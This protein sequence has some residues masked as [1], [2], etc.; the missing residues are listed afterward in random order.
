VS[1]QVSGDQDLPFGQQWASRTPYLFPLTNMIIWGMGLPLGAAAWAGWAIAGW[2][3]FRRRALVHLIPWL[4][5]ALYFLWQGG[6][7]NPTM[8]YFA[9]LY[10]VLVIFAAWALVAL[11]NRRTMLRHAQEP[12]QGRLNDPSPPR[13]LS[14]TKGRA[15]ERQTIVGIIRRWSVVGGRWS[16]VFVVISTLCW[17]YAFTRIYTRPHSRIAAS[18]WIYDHIPPGSTISSEYWDDGL[19]LNL[20][21]HSASQYV[22]IEMHPYDEDDPIKYTGFLDAKGKYAPGLFDQLDKLD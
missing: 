1:Q 15:G 6:I 10:G 5:I 20:D 9:L 12:A 21:G 22:G 3:I 7:L 14:L 2:Q 17:A 8:R 16:V 19:P 18:R 4:S 11:W 13:L